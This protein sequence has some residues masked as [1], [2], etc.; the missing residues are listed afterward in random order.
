MADLI[1]F[2]I[3]HFQ[4]FDACPAPNDLSALLEEVGFDGVEI[5]HALMLLEILTAE[6]LIS[7]KQ[8]FT[9]SLRVYTVDETDILP[10]EVIDLLS[11]LSREQALNPSQRELVVHALLCMPP[12]DITVDLAKVLSLL[13]LWI[14]RSELP[15]L[16]GD[17]L[18]MALHG[19]TVMH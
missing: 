14:Q 13:V 12:E 10:P 8:Q 3:E 11:F 1:A 7:A 15:V 16:I 4:D 5:N 2:L 6:P 17:E 19:Q 9:D 18:M